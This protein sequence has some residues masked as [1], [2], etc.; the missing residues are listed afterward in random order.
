MPLAQ[1]TEKRFSYA[2][3]VAWP[4]DERWELIEG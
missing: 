2:D 4:D 3:Y 1:K